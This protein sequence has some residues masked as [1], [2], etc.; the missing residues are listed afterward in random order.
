MGCCR[1][2]LERELVYRMRPIA[3]VI[4]HI[5]PPVTEQRQTLTIRRP[6][7]FSLQ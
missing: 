6:T 7:H 1:I 3:F 2:C 4:L 5:N